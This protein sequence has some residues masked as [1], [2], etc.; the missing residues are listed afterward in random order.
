MPAPV[1]SPPDE[2][3]ESAVAVADAVE[4]EAADNEVAVVPDAVV[5]S[6]LEADVVVADTKR[7]KSFFSH[8]MLMG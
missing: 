5:E 2:P 4:A 6:V 8:K 7:L 3:S 1:D